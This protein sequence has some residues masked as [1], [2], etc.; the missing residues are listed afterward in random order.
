[1]NRFR[2][3]ATT[4]YYYYQWIGSPWCGAFAKMTLHTPHGLTFGRHNDIFDDQCNITAGIHRQ[5]QAWFT[6]ET[7][8]K[9]KWK[10]NREKD[11]LKWSAGVLCKWDD[12]RSGVSGELARLLKIWQLRHCG[13]CRMI[14]NKQMLWW[15]H[16]QRTDEYESMSHCEL[17]TQLTQF[18]YSNWFQSMRVERKRPNRSR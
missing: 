3:I 14:L 7:V 8:R 4:F 17:T 10:R 11:E 2:S 5:R 16:V 1:M 18:V 13:N 15:K 9:S 12:V 6:A